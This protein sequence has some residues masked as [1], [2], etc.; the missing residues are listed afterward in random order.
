MTTAIPGNPAAGGALAA[1][2]LLAA[3]ALLSACGGVDDDDTAPTDD[4]DS[5]VGDDDDSASGPTSSITAVTFAATL[6]GEADPDW[7]GDHGAVTDLH[8]TFQII[9]WD[10]LDSVAI[11]CRQRIGFDAQVRFGDAMSGELCEAC[12]GRLRL[13]SA[14]VLPPDD[15][16]DG[17]TDLPAEIDLAFLVASGDVTDPGD[18]RAL[19]LV[20]AWDLVAD[21]TPLGADGHLLASEVIDRYA[22][23]GLEVLYIASI[24]AGG[25][26]G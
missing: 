12:V 11:H 23:A 4:D 22:V 26:S 16:D 24:R 25:W 1:A 9:Y 5:T 21:D 15:Y 2:A 17:C 8:G 13:T 20:P 3:L 18:F 14:Y 7:T 6:Q 19:D 10:S